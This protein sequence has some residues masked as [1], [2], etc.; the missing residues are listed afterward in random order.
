MNDL[1]IECL[2]SMREQCTRDAWKAAIEDDK[3]GFV[4]VFDQSMS[5][6]PH[7]DMALTCS[8]FQTDKGVSIP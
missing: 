8:R 7:S 6:I 2:A 1:V 5:P 3:F 4:D